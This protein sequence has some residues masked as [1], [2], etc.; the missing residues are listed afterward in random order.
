MWTLVGGKTTFQGRANCICCVRKK[1]SKWFIPEEG[2]GVAAGLWL[3]T[4][5]LGDL[6]NGDLSGR[7]RK[8]VRPAFGGALRKPREAG[9]ST[10]LP[11][12]KANLSN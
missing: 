7:V 8:G 12:S 5:Y 9:S 3:S 2:D 4:N 6:E 10:S 1:L 11:H